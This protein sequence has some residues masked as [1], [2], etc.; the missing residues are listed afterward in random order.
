MKIRY[1]TGLTLV[2]LALTSCGGGKPVEINPDAQTVATR[3]N[4]VLST[5]A[6]LSG[7]A[8][9]RGQAWVAADPKNQGQIT[10]HVSI[11]NAVPNAVHPWHVHRGECGSDQGIAGPADAYPPLKVNND[12]RAEGTAKLSTSLPRSGRYFVNV[13][14]SSKN[15]ST[16]VA[17]GN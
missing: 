6:E 14:A 7:V 1:L 5:P 12:G 10:A 9:I 17:C 4:A 16:I 11:S 8:D 3:W 13:H 2:G 15:M